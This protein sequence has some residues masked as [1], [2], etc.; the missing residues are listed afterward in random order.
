VNC[1]IFYHDHAEETQLMRVA[2]DRTDKL[3]TVQVGDVRIFMT[4]ARAR[5]LRDQLA[6]EL[7][8]VAA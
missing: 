3:Y 5:E 6:R 7:P 8:E 2:L 4:E 1:T